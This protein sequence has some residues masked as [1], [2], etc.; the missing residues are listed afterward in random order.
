MPSLDS[1]FNLILILNQHTQKATNKG[2]PRTIGIHELFLLQRIDRKFI[3][4]TIARDNGGLAPLRKDH[5]TR[6]VGVGLGH[7]GDFERHLLQIAAEI[8]LLGVGLRLALIGKDKVRVWHGSGHLIGKEIDDERSGQIQTKCL[9]LLHGMVGDDLQALHADGQE[10]SGDVIHARGVVNVLG[11]L[12]FEV[13]R[14]EVVRSGQIG[15]QRTLAI[16]HQD[17]AG[18][19]R[20]VI[21]LHVM[22]QD[23]VLFAGAF[24]QL[25]SKFILS[26]TAHEGGTF[27]FCAG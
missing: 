14:F 18:T 3:H 16:L 19:R 2:I 21:V 10:E 6:S 7:G 24:L 12:C 4:L 15:D 5:R 9:V 17:G 20:R 8:V 27:G 13:A 23:A 25:S 22:H 11:K 26:N 1:G